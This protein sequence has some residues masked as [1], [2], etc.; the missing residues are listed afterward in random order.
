MRFRYEFG[1]RIFGLTLGV[2]VA[3]LAIVYFLFEHQLMQAARTRTGDELEVR[4]ELVRERVGREGELLGAAAWDRLADTLGP[5]ARAR[6]TFV[7]P[8]GVVIGDSRIALGDLKAVDNH[9]NRP[10]VQRALAGQFAVSERRSKTTGQLTY[11][12]ARPLIAQGQV[13]GV[14]R[15]ALEQ[16][17]LETAT[18]PLTRALWV[19]FSMGIVLALMSALLASFF[20]NGPV[21]HL[22]SVANRLAEGDLT[23]RARLGDTN[24]LDELS[25]GLNYLGSSLSRTLS[26][27]RAERDR[28][29]GILSSMDEGVLFLDEDRRIALVNPKLREMLLLEGEVTNRS[30]LEVIRHAD[31]KELIDSAYDDEEEGDTVH[32]DIHIGGLKPRNLLVRARRLEGREVGL[33]AVFMDVTEM[34]RLENLRR[35]F[36]ANVSHELRT[37]VTTIRSAAETLETLG[38]DA[39]EMRV[40]F[41][42]IISR[43]AHRLQALVEDLLDLSRIE[44]RQYSLSLEQL[45]PGEVIELVFRLHRER[46]MA[47]GIRLTAEIPADFP[48]LH[49][50]RKA[51]EHVLSNLVDNAVK[52]AGS[53]KNITV[54]ALAEPDMAC[55]E[56]ADDGVGIESRHLPRLFERFYRVD[57]GRSR[58]Q[59]GTGL[60][61]SIV[62]NLTESMAGHVSVKS[63]L[64]Q[65]TVFQV[66]LPY[67]G[68]RPGAGSVRPPR[69]SY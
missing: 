20:L 4:L 44:S 49:V 18:L 34:R 55:L 12:V 59:G 51:L 37:P 9:A 7:D 1:L 32:G 14:A 2:V 41:L 60:G 46:A 47:R 8:K 22:S 50:D 39:P 40:K 58:A 62:K 31:L 45:H 52:Y 21:R 13:L 57:P 25:R 64:G 35:E 10:E 27:L 16:T 6:V 66:W 65:G 23:A 15:L 28:M 5:I 67:A 26:A 48:R 69:V 63:E 54:R 56:V 19:T 11:Y 42:D 38:A 3:V 68:S 33:V 43:N 24:E 30:V 29:G 36:V 17:A 53:G 61:L